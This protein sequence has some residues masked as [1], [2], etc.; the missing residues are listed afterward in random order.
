MLP[1]TLVRLMISRIRVAGVTLA[2]TLWAFLA[3]FGLL[4]LS[5]AGSTSGLANDHDARVTVLLSALSQSLG[6][7]F[8]FSAM[9]TVRASPS[10]R[11]PPSHNHSHT[12]IPRPTG[13]R[14]LVGTDGRSHRRLK[15]VRAHSASGSSHTAKRADPETDAPRRSVAAKG[16]AAAAVAAV[17]PPVAHPQT[18]PNSAVPCVFRLPRF[19]LHHHTTTTPTPH[20]RALPGVSFPTPVV[21]SFV[22]Q[23]GI[24]VLELRRRP[25]R[26]LVLPL[27]LGQRARHQL[28]DAQQRVQDQARWAHDEARTWLGRGR[29][30]RLRVDDVGRGPAYPKRRGGR[31]QARIR[32][33]PSRARRDNLGKRSTRARLQ[34]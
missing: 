8:I 10:T 11:D 19:A 34:W 4:F 29:G 9:V 20:A 14:R 12:R 27:H 13:R 6:L 22:F 33:L 1:A 7:A 17:E 15:A 23:V 31:S 16:A 21:A 24:G 18:L 25:K 28:R 30:L 32:G 3:S 5:F 26:D 2:L